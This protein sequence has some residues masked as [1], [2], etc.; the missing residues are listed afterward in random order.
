MDIYVKIFFYRQAAKTAEV[1]NKR[2]EIKA[3][4]LPETRS[5]LTEKLKGLEILSH[6]LFY[7]PRI[8]SDDAQGF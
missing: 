7:T 1:F 8:D 4:F 5:S 3:M 2:R 6:T